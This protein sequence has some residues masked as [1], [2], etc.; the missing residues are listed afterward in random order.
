MIRFLL[1]VIELII[2]FVLMLPVMLIALIIRGGSKKNAHRLIQATLRGEFR[3][4]M[5]LTGCKVTVNGKDNI[6][7]LAEDGM[8]IEPCLFVANHRSVFDIVMAYA[9][10]KQILA[11]VGKKEARGIPLV[12]W[13]MALMNGIFLDRKDLKQGLECI[14]KAQSLI[15]DD[16]ISVWIFPEGTRSKGADEKELLEFKPGS[17]RVATKTGAPIVPVFFSGTRDIFENHAPFVRACNVSITYGEP[18][19]PDQLDDDEKKHIG[20]FFREII[21]EM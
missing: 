7:I 19:W 8:S 12:G 21:K 20:E 2:Y 17:F 10:T 16:H 9:Y 14:L 6:P 15:K 18:I 4:L 11:F 3:V 1:C 13:L 5:W